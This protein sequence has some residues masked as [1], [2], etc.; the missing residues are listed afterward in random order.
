M[1]IMPYDTETT[2]LPV[3][4][5]PSEGE[6]QPHIVQF[7]AMLVDA[8]TREIKQE[9]D[10][11]IKPDGWVIPQE[12][13]EIHGITTERAMDEG[14]P[15]STVVEWIRDNWNPRVI[16]IGH[17][18]GFDERLIRIAL[19]RYADEEFCETWKGGEKACTGLLAK[20]IMQ[21]PPKGRYGY[22]M[23]KLSEAYEHFTGKPLENAHSA[24]ADTRACL[25]VYWAI[26]DQ[27]IAAV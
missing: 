3:W 11:I 4:N 18:Q 27:K 26:Q 5:E 13:A 7:A 16:R 6:N 22:K 8:D 25:D 10:I 17:N 14:V 21:M 20:P 19:K 12:T 24:M 23:P 15:E 1:I 9:I 2:G